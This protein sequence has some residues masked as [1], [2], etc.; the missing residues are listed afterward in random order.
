MPKAWQTP[1]KVRACGVS[2]KGVNTSR[3]PAIG[4][5]EKIP[6]R[7]DGSVGVVI[8]GNHR[9]LSWV[10]A[11]V[12]RRQMLVEVTPPFAPPPP[13]ILSSDPHV[14][15]PPLLTRTMVRGW[16]ASLSACRAF[17]SCRNAISPTTSVTARPSPA[18]YLT[19]EAEER[20]RGSV[21]A[22]VKD[23]WYDGRTS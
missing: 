12:I 18:E 1:A 7:T 2:K 10:P 17:R 19:R 14:P 5:K 22:C 4:K 3:W 16:G 13:H 21:D 15:P 23:L 8:A 11:I 20:G 9:H 6:A